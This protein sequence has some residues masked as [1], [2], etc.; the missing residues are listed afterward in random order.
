MKPA[1]FDYHRPRRRD[2]ALALLAEHGSDAKPLAGGQ[3]LIPAMNFRLAMPA[4]LVDLNAIADLSLHHASRTAALRIGAHDAASRASSAATMCAQSRRSARGHAVH[5]AR[6]DPHARNDRRQPGARRSGGRA[7]GRDAGARCHDSRSQNAQGSRDVPA[8]DFFTG[9]F[10]TALEPGELADR[11]RDSGQ[12]R[13]PASD[14]HRRSRSSRGGTATSRWRASPRVVDAG[15]RAAVCTRARIAL[16]GV[17]DRPMLAANGRAR[18]RGPVAVGR[19]SF[20]PPRMPPRATT[21]IRRATST[22]RAGIDGTW[23]ACSRAR[24]AGSAAL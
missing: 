24:V 12:R 23:R 16:F 13:R 17:G 6:G 21:S 15:R 10:S 3:S 2:E 22:R 18:A 7:A 5:R 8:A 19:T 9:L 11:D 20:A 1:P 14:R 4:V